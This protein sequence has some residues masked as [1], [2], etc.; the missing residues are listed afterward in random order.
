MVL[1][2]WSRGTGTKKYKVELWTHGKNSKKIRTIQFGSK[3]YNQYKDTTPLKLY[4]NKDTLDKKKRKNYF[5]RHKKNY[6]IYSPDWLSK[7]YLW[8]K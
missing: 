8:S 3:N 4:S 6:P 5:A 7:K 1:R 2:N